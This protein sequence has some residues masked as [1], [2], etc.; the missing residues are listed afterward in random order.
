M[1]T[2]SR[3]LQYLGIFFVFLAP[4]HAL[5]QEKVTLSWNIPDSNLFYQTDLSPK[6]PGKD[7][8][9]FDFDNV[10]KEKGKTEEI[11]KKISSLKFPDD[12]NMV[13][14]MENLPNGNIKA[15]SFFQNWDFP[16]IVGREKAEGDENLIKIKKLMNTVPQLEGEIDKKGRVKS[17]YLQQSQKNIFALL[18]ELPAKPVQ[19]GDTWEINMYCIEMGGGFTADSAER[20]NRVEL[21]EI[22]TGEDGVKIAK[23]DYMLAEKI[24]GKMTN[25]STMERDP[26]EMTC[27]YLGKHEFNVDKGYWRGVTGEMT[28]TSKGVMPSNMNQ[29]IVMKAIDG[30]PEKIRQE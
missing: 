15:T 27:S 17:F 25:L 13:T 11:R 1:N 18:F 12:L 9:E 21:K 24:T 19:V 30:L 22:T 20:L 3:K 8:I 4:L 5:A 16:S 23:V 6:E 10:F 7:F 14:I 29:R 28:I 2:V 26:I